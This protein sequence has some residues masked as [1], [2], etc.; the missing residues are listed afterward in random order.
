MLVARCVEQARLCGYLRLTLWTNSILADARRLYERAGFAL[1][2]EE[3]HFS[4]GKNLIGQYWR[5]DL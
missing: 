3:P 4:F 5:L 1:E 2:R